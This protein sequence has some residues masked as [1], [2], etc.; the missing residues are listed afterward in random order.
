MEANC[1]GIAGD[2]IFAPIFTQMN[3]IPGSSNEVL[4]GGSYINHI[5]GLKTNILV[6]FLIQANGVIDF[7]HHFRTH[8]SIKP[9]GGS[10]DGFGQI[11]P[12]RDAGSIYTTITYEDTSTDRWV[13]MKLSRGFSTI[14]WAQE[15]TRPTSNFTV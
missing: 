15:I 13:F 11:V 5:T 8:D 9:Q 2:N 4:A 14:N 3:F 12:S 6:E 7:T 10:D 1:Y